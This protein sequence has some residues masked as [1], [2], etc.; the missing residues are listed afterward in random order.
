ML[1][2]IA[3]I[4]GSQDHWMSKR[5]DGVWK[6]LLDVRT[7]HNLLTYP[8]LAMILHWDG[9]VVIKIN[10]KLEILNADTYI[11]STVIGWSLIAKWLEIQWT[12]YHSFCPYM[13]GNLQYIFSHFEHVDINFVS[14]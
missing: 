7:A 2:I 4:I 3:P 11:T 10:L 14:Q 1:S 8:N 12:K 5:L 6:L 13:Y 9:F